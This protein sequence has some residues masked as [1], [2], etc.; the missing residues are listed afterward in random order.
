MENKDKKKK[1]KHKHKDKSKKKKDKGKSKDKKNKSTNKS[2]HSKMKKRNSSSDDDS[3]DEESDHWSAG[4]S[5]VNYGQ[6]VLLSDDSNLWGDNLSQD[7]YDS[8]NPDCPLNAYHIDSRPRLLK[9]QDIDP[10]NGNYIS[11]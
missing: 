10:N 3:D 1:D 4:D 11:L 8:D 5:G 7:L 9:L 2:G 6:P